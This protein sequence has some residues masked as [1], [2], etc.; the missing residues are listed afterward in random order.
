MPLNRRK[1]RWTH[2]LPTAKQLLERNAA[3]EDVAE[4]AEDAAA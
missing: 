2:P 1:R 4:A 3:V